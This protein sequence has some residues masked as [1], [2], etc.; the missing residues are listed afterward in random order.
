MK[1]PVVFPFVQAL[2]QNIGLVSMHEIVIFNSLRGHCR[3]N[4]WAWITVNHQ[5]GFPFFLLGEPSEKVY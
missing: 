3:G 4:K 2:D 1:L 5:S